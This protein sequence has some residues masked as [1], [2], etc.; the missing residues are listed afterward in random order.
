MDLLS[1][2]ATYILYRIVSGIRRIIDQLL[3]VDRTGV[4][5]FNTLFLDKPLSVGL[6][7]SASI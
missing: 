1:I 3:G 7:D 6:R 2:M 4:P 5:L